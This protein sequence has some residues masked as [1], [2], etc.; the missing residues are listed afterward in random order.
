MN[1]DYKK[2][3]GLPLA[4]RNVESIL[5]QNLD[6]GW[7]K[8]NGRSIVSPHPTRHLTEEEFI[9]LMNLDKEFSNFIKNL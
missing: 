3:L 7:C 8:L 4:K 6:K 9:D 1:N 2:Y 5:Y